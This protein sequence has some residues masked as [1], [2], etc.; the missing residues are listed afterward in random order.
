MMNLKQHKECYSVFP[1]IENQF[2]SPI[3]LNISQCL[4]NIDKQLLPCSMFVQSSC[5]YISFEPLFDINRI[6]ILE[7]NTQKS[8]K[9]M[10]KAYTSIPIIILS[11]QSTLLDYFINYTINRLNT[12]I[13]QILGVSIELLQKINLHM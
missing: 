7:K 6:Y 12:G 1:N 2:L 11:T 4:L 5:S 9:F 13:V 8:F 3:D 10:L